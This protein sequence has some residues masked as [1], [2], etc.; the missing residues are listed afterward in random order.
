MS[1]IK[2][3]D[4]IN[5]WLIKEIQKWRKQKDGALAVDHNIDFL[6]QTALKK[7][8]QNHFPKVKK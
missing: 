5:S 1:Y 3:N 6:F 8:D 4:H 2:W 7:L